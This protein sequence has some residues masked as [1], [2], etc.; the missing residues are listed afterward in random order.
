[1]KNKFFSLLA[2]IISHSGF[3]QVPC[4]ASLITSVPSG[5]NNTYTFTSIIS[6]SS[7]PGTIYFWTWTNGTQTWSNSTMTNNTNLITFTASGTYTVCSYSFSSGCSNNPQACVTLTVTNSNCS[8]NLNVNLSG[9]NANATVNILP[10]NPTNGIFNWTLMG[11]ISNPNTYTLTTST[12]TT[13]FP[14][15]AAGVYDLCVTPSSVGCSNFVSVCQTFTV[16]GTTCS[17]NLNVNINGNNATAIVNISPNN[18]TNGIFNWSLWGPLNNPVNYTTTTNT[19]SLNLNTLAAGVYDLCVTASS[20]GCNNNVTTCQSFTISNNPTFCQPTLSIISF[21]GSV[22]HFSLNA[23]FAGPNSSYHWNWSGPSNGNTVTSTS[24]VNINFNPPG[25]YWICSYVIDST[26]CS[27]YTS[28]CMSV[29]VSGSTG[30]AQ[31]HKFISEYYPI[32]VHEYF[33]IRFSNHEKTMV[34]ITSI[35]G[36]LVYESEFFTRE[37]TLPVYNLNAGIYIVEVINSEGIIDRIKLMKE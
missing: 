14:N 16:S 34:R 37:V 23:P 18:P 19:N 12:N 10:N 24:T 4:S 32:P 6:P 13:S 9:N 20:V 8:A 36:K 7:S 5:S 17:A 35:N 1:M 21:S 26:S 3:T 28:S 22:Y 2:L 15:L 25:V 33:Y 29:T 11:P 27:S 31:I 30:L